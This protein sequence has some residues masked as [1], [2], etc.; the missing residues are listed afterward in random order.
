MTSEPLEKGHG[1]QALFGINTR[2]AD[3]ALHAVP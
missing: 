1:H 3:E 2:L